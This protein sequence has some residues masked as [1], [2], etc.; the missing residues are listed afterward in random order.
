MDL[1]LI[2]RKSYVGT[3]RIEQSEVKSLHERPDYIFLSIDAVSVIWICIR[4]WLVI[5]STKGELADSILLEIILL[6]ASLIISR[7]GCRLTIFW[8]LYLGEKEYFHKGNLV[9]QWWGANNACKLCK[10]VRN[11]KL[12]HDASFFSFII[13]MHIPPAIF[14]DL[15]T[16]F[17]A[18]YFIIQVPNFFNFWS[19]RNIQIKEHH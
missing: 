13:V 19:W 14:L 10:K 3:L 9:I 12:L 16:T 8:T 7:Y 17:F 6:S 15:M 2:Y 4:S 18:L 5:T 1:L 11:K